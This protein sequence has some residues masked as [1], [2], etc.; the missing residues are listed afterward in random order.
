MH[1][2]YWN[3]LFSAQGILKG[4]GVLVII[5]ALT[6]A[7]CAV[8]GMIAGS[9]P[10][11]VLL[12]LALSL[13]P[14][15]MSLVAYIFAGRFMY[16]MNYLPDGLRVMADMFFPLQYAYYLNSPMAGPLIAYVIA[17]ALLV[18]AA[19][20]LYAKRPLEKAGN[21]LVFRFMEVA[22][23]AICALAGM[24]VG[25]YGLGKLAPADLSYGAFFM[26]GM[27][28][29]FFIAFMLAR[30]VVKQTIHVWNKKTGA[31][32]GI[33]AL[34]AAL[35]FAVVKFDLTGFE[36]RI[37]AVEEV[38]SVSVELRGF[39]TFSLVRDFDQYEFSDPKNLEHIR[40]FQQRIVDNR[41]DLRHIKGYAAFEVE[42][43]LNSGALARR[44]WPLPYSIYKNDSD[45]EAI[46]ESDEFRKQNVLK[47]VESVELRSFIGNNFLLSPEEIESF[48]SAMNKDLETLSGKDFLAWRTPIAHVFAEPRFNVF[49]GVEPGDENAVAWLKDNGYYDKVY[50]WTDRVN[51]IVLRKMSQEG[52]LLPEPE[53][54]I[55]DPAEIK[56][57]IAYSEA[58]R[59]EDLEY[60][61]MELH[62]GEDVYWSSLHLNPGNPY[63][64]KIRSHLADGA[65]DL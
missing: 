7:I 14:G 1:W 46:L 55:T 25:G 57:A 31:Q 18:I 62:V 15:S 34:V 12:A 54:A 29:G 10:M 40:A 42:W 48:V 61:K 3:A 24:T 59:Y 51:K 52:E 28:A 50:G 26:I 56:E 11:H 33:S 58:G 19:S 20:F 35:L 13:T 32:L 43:K 5:S 27:A 47:E 17:T 30:M 4:F 45:I 23:C 21:S 65:D 22:F 8:A 41:S 60:Y 36:R 64:E 44:S 16:G 37:P 39:N 53:I 38:E 6:L 49:L 2:E 9:S 63:L